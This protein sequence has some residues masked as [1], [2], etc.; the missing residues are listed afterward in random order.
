MKGCNVCFTLKIVLHKPYDD[1][2][3]LS[4]PTY[5]WKDLSIDFV[6]GLP[7]SANW[8]SKTF[9]SI[10]AIIDPLI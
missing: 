4:M 7:V 2:Q 3:L 5:C 10:L 1:L 6:T 9:D 8:K